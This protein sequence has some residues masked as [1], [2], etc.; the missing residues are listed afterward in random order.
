M[1]GKAFSPLC[2]DPGKQGEH[3]VDG[4]HLGSNS[5]SSSQAIH[6]LLPDLRLLVGATW[7]L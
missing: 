6:P 3:C 1:N 5:P 4:G 7:A 2:G